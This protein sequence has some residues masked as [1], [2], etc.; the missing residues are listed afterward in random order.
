MF[1][2][3]QLPGPQPALPQVLLWEPLPG[4]QRVLLRVFS[5]PLLPVRRGGEPLRELLPELL[6]ER[7]VLL[8]QVLA[9]L[10]LPARQGEP[11][12]ELLP[13]LLA[14]QGALLPQVLVPLVLPARQGEPLRELL[15]ELL[16]GVPLLF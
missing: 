3:A 11:L 4:L 7:W 2:P 8:P 12:R 10:V 9:A 6:A 1:L 5:L 13:E 14:E 15:P 16:A